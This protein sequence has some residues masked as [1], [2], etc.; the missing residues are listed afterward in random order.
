MGLKLRYN[1]FYGVHHNDVYDAYAQFYA[2]IG[3]PLVDKG[4]KSR[5]L[6][7]HE[8]ENNW[9]VLKLDGGWEREV[10]QQAYL[11]TSKILSCPGFFI[12]VY[13]GE[14]WGFELFS[15]GE[16]IDNFVNDTEPNSPAYYPDDGSCDGNPDVIVEQFPYL[17]KDDVTPYL[18]R[19]IW[20]YES[21]MSKEEYDIWE[22]KT[23]VP[24]RPGDEYTRFAECSVLNF[25]RMLGI[26]VAVR[27]RYVELDAPPYRS[28]W[29]EP[30]P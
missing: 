12:Y 20:P 21:G 4:D 28:F 6:A 16:V 14:Y 23:D 11:F 13:D 5:E 3:Q 17:A 8:N 10:R 26:M 29:I 7:I 18:V 27:N 1:L 2:G 9:V 30:S 22:K 19:K 25:L 24:P 15:N